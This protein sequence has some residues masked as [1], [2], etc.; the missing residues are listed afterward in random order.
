MKTSKYLKR[1]LPSTGPHISIAIDKSL[2]HRDTN[3]AIIPVDRKLMKIPVDAP[4]AYDT[5]KGGVERGSRK[6][7]ADQV[8]KVFEKVLDFNEENDLCYI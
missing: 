1:V 8:V 6:D 5:V 7:L 2:P 4:I 3:H